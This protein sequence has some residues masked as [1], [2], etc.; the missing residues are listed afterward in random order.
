MLEDY[1]ANL[2]KNDKSS[3]TVISYRNDILI[4]FEDLHIRPDGFVTATDVKKLIHRLCIH[5]K[6]NHWPLPL[7]IVG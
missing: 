6:G 2:Q 3:K 5:K 1:I 4:F 7:L